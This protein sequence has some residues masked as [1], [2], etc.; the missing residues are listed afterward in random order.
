MDSKFT[1]FAKAN[2][3]QHREI[4]ESWSKSTDILERALASAFI[5]A[6]EVT[7]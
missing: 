4:I 6:L 7:A 2:Y 5:D 3:A 1:N